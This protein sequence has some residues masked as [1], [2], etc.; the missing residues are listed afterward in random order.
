MSLSGFAFRVAALATMCVEARRGPRH[1]FAAVLLAVLAGATAALAEQRIA[2]MRQT[3]HKSE[4]MV[5][6]YIRDGALFRDNASA[7]VGL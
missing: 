7:K 4:R 5:R 2:L 6:T 1:A 3:G